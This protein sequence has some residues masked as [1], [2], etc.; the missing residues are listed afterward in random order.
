MKR[1]M[2]RSMIEWLA[3]FGATE[4]NEVTRMLYSKERMSAQQAMKA[5]DGEKLIIYF[6]SDALGGPPV[7]SF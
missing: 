2:L 3:F 6:D 4:S 5:E 7:E 1:M